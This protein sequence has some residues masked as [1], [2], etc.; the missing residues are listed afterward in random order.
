MI[1]F[2][3]FSI[4]VPQIKVLFSSYV[5]QYFNYLLKYQRFILTYSCIFTYLYLYLK[6]SFIIR[7]WYV[8]VLY[9]L[10][11]GFDGVFI[12][13]SDINDEINNFYSI[14]ENIRL[15]NI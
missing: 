7:I 5:K 13:I 4:A 2:I 10:R 6:Y 1:E 14:V 3:L 15:N 11:L 12:I 9:F 8:L